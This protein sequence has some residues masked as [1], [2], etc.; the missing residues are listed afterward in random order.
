MGRQDVQ[1]HEKALFQQLE[2]LQAQDSAQSTKSTSPVLCAKPQTVDNVEVSTQCSCPVEQNQDPGLGE[3]QVVKVELDSAL[4][5]GSTDVLLHNK[6]I[7]Q[8]NQVHFAVLLSMMFS[9]K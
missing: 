6:P 2:K 1:G 8:A 4:N 9:I 5:Q 7:T 3:A